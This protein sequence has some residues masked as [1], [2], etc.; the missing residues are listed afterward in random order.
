MRAVLALASAAFVLVVPAPTPGTWQGVAGAS[1]HAL[2]LKEG[3]LSGEGFD[4]LMKE[5]E[6]TQFVVL[7]EE[8]NTAEIP[9]F[10]AALFS[11]LHDRLGY[12]YVALEQDPLMMERASTKPARGD[13]GVLER[14]AREHPYAYTFV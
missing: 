3:R 14:I 9:P 8:H 2:E 10:T 4:F 13:R 6:P 5:L 11:A 7:G 1:R 12:Q